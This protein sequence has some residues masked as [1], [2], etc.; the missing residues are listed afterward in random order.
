MSESAMEESTA[1]SEKN[2]HEQEMGLVPFLS[3]ELWIET[4]SGSQILA[5]MVESALSLLSR[6][7]II[8]IDYDL[9]FEKA[10][11]LLDKGHYGEGINL[12]LQCSENNNIKA[13]CKLALCY[14][15]GTGVEKNLELAFK[16]YRK[17]AELESPYAMYCIGL[18]YMN[19]E[20]VGLNQEEAVKWFYKAAPE[21]GTGFSVA[22]DA[23][24]ICFRDAKGVSQDYN[25]SFF[26]FK[27]GSENGLASSQSFLGDCY[28]KGY[29]TSQDKKMA[30]YW[31][32]KS[33]EQGN[34]NS[35][36]NISVCYY[37]GA[38]VEQNIIKAYKWLKLAILGGKASDAKNLELIKNKMSEDQID[39]GDELVSNFRAITGN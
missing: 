28:R 29:G 6:K 2:P 32:E 4:G 14:E 24:G 13:Q 17:S 11:K 35:Q 19:G 38:G 10:V 36:N 27:L 9:L 31:Y 37:T 12:L 30:A 22:Y 21:D 20:G 1:A 16:W 5:E 15:Q 26:Y 7:D 8:A 23:L 39:E 18:C 3:R 34:V 33:A 25:K